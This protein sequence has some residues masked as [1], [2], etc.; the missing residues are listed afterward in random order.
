[1]TTI[2]PSKD[3]NDTDFRVLPLC[4]EDATN[5]GTASDTGELQGATISSHT[6]VAQDASITVD[7]SD[8]ASI[9]YQGITY[10]VNTAVTIWLSGGTIGTDGEVLVTVTLS[11]GRVLD[12]TV[13]IPIEAH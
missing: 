4:S 8:L 3:T 9:S 11:D 12:E 10:A 6:A 7:S 5:D 2:F 13:K 1:M